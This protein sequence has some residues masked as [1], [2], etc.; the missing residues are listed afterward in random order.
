MITPFMTEAIKEE[1]TDDFQLEQLMNSEEIQGLPA[2]Q[3]QKVDSDKNMAKPLQVPSLLDE[4]TE[5]FFTFKNPM[6]IKEEQ[7]YHMSQGPKRSSEPAATKASLKGQ[8][9]AM[10]T[11]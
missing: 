8:Q 11:M 10:E 6:L 1:M 2:P 5:K 9:K 3:N 7:L 4:P